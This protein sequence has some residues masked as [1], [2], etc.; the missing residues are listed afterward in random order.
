MT[1][2]FQAEDMPFL[3]AIAIHPWQEAPKGAFADYLDETGRADYAAYIRASIGLKYQRPISEEFKACA[4]CM[5]DKGHS[6]GDYWNSVPKEF[7]I[8]S[9]RDNKDGFPTFIIISADEFVAHSD[10][11][12]EI[13]PL[14]EIQID[15][16]K[17]AKQLQAI[18]KQPRLSQLEALHL[19]AEN[20]IAISQTEQLLPPTE[21]LPAQAGGMI[22]SATQL[23]AL[24][25]FELGIP[26]T[27]AGLRAV[28]D[29][30][31]A[32]SWKLLA[33]SRGDYADETRQHLN[34]PATLPS[35]N[36]HVYWGSSV[37]FNAGGVA[38]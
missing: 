37:R 26:L 4:C 21:R 16:I 7:S 1:D 28:V 32:K 27:D 10:A 18:L 6:Q 19:F 23:G 11:V 29:S 24:N 15:D 34:D 38:V 2:T 5:R 35:L 14:R 9:V 20:G 25:Y 36:N 30:P 3:R 33:V 12:F 13:L 8:K 31:T 22:A 17:S